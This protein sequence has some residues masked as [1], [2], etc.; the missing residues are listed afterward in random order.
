MPLS[1]LCTRGRAQKAPI[2]RKK[3]T[4]SNE[5]LNEVTFSLVLK[6]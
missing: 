2:G 1:L 6:V 3:M 4:S 5:S